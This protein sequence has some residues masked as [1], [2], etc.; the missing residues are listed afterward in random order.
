MIRTLTVTACLLATAPL[1]HAQRVSKITGEKLLQ[2]CSSPH[3]KL[4]CEGYISG[5]ADAIARA[6]KDM[7]PTQGR[8][9]AG[10]AC[11]PDATTADQMHAVV[12][13]FL[14]AHPE[15]ASGPAAIPAY[16][17]LHGAFPCKTQ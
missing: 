11:I 10:S 9:F 13:S 17:A 7:S 16:D 15:T 8:S 5:M 6:E 14:R 2:L 3:G 1:A 4:I 12:V